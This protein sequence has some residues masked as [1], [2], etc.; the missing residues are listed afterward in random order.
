L[1]L[2]T[3]CVNCYEDIFA[4]VSHTR[5]TSSKA[6]EDTACVNCNTFLAA[7]TS[8]TRPA[9]ASDCEATNCSVCDSTLAAIDDHNWGEWYITTAASNLGTANV[10]R[11]CKND[12]DH[13]ETRTNEAPRVV[14]AMLNLTSDI[15]LKYTVSIPEGYTE[16]GIGTY[17]AGSRTRSD[18]FVASASA[19]AYA[20]GGQVLTDLG[21]LPLL[22]VT[23][24]AQSGGQVMLC[25][26]VEFASE[27]YMQSIVFGNSDTV[28]CLSGHL[29]SVEPLLGLK[30]K[31]FTTDKIS[32]ITTAQMRNWTITLTV[33]PAVL[34]LGVAITILVRRKYA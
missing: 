30:F 12:A 15:T 19:I 26:S 7:L 9:S 8:H 21:E 24:D 33:V 29:G 11:V 5:P 23:E 34:V 28:Q 4:Y 10:K 32:L 20:N 31:P 14:N 25:S 16:S 3:Y 1:C 13:I 18:L 2:D 6:C 22:A 27:K 17:T